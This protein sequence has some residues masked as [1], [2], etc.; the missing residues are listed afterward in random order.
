MT[1]GGKKKEVAL[2]IENAQKFRR[3]YVN[4]LT[5]LFFFNGATDQSIN[6]LSSPPPFL[7][8]IKI[9]VSWHPYDKV[10]IT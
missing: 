5:H 2:K 1:V 7:P 3:L 8:Q 10:L 6:H 4:K 9:G